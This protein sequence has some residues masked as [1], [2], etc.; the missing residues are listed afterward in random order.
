MA[1][2]QL[3]NANRITYKLQAISADK[4]LIT[5][6]FL[7]FW[8]ET[9]QGTP[10]HF[11]YYYILLF[12]WPE[13]KPEGPLFSAEFVC[14]CVWLSLSDRHFYRSTWTNFDETWSQGPYSDLV[15]LDHNGLDRPQR[16]RATP[17]WKFQKK[18]F[19]KSQNSNFEILVDHFCG[20]VSCVL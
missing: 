10:F 19:K 18:F 11:S 6:G 8:M 5:K 4:L 13:W 7:K 2:G 14:L 9:A 20:C 15:W 16:D 1:T 17:F 3:A 12:F